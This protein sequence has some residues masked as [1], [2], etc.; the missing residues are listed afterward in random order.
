MVVAAEHGH[1]QT[2]PTSLRDREWALA[3]IISLAEI[4]LLCT[5]LEML[6]L[7]LG[8]AF[9]L[10][11]TVFSGNISCHEKYGLRS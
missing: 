1:G 10:D 3:Q 11:G 6:D 7:L 9:V 8:L 4:H 5:V 2:D